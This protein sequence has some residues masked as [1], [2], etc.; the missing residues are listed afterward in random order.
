MRCVCVCVCVCMYVCVCVC[1]CV[2][3]YVC[4]Y[5]CVCVDGSGGHLDWFNIS[6]NDVCISVLHCRLSVVAIR[7]VVGV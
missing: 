2:C 3:I 7:E 1:V 4:V 6:I 5:V